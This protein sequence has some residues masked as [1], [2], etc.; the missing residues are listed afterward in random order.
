MKRLSLILWLFFL[1]FVAIAQ[2]EIN[3]PSFD[4]GQKL[5]TLNV[6]GQ[7]EGLWIEDT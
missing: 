4:F 3:N 7:R 6:N 5:N 2:E 1:S